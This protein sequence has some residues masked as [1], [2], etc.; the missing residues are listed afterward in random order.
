MIPVLHSDSGTANMRFVSPQQWM[1]F[2]H[3]EVNDQE[4]KLLKVDTWNSA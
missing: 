3:N 1:S 4:G 2:L